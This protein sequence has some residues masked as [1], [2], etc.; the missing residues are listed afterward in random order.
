MNAVFKKDAAD[1]EILL[2][3]VTTMA[4]RPKIEGDFWAILDEVM[5]PASEDEAEA[6]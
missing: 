3:V 1:A 5:Q 2:P 6:A 4:I